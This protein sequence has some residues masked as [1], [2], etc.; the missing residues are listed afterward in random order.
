MADR[1][2]VAIRQ[3]R[4]N[5]ESVQQSLKSRIRRETHNRKKILVVDE[6]MLEKVQT[7]KKDDCMID[8]I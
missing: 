7:I 4:T 2:A 8:Y 3:P 5:S 6:V 1:W